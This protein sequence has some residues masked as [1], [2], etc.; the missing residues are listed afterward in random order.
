M[1]VI[2]TIK[3]QNIENNTFKN[4]LKIIQILFKNFNKTITG[5]ILRKFILL[6]KISQIIVLWVGASMVLKGN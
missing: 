3:T 1:N 5:T 4:G 2:Q 6:Q